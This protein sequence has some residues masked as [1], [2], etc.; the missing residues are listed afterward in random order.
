MRL[1]HYRDNENHEIDLL[2]ERF[3]GALL[4]I[5]VKAGSNISNQDFKHMRW[6]KENLTQDRPFTGV[7]LHTGTVAGSMGDGMWAA[8]FG[9][10]W[11]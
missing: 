11:S 2:I 9:C 10:L 6:F 7:L 1:Y 3:D 5:E 4:G 8:P